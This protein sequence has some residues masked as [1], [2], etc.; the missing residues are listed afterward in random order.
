MREV[1]GAVARSTL[2]AVPF[3][4]EQKWSLCVCEL[5]SR[6]GTHPFDAAVPGT[7]KRARL[8]ENIAAADVELTPEDLREIDA[9][10]SKIT[11]QGARYPRELEQMVGR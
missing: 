2:R 6:L 1:P 3:T 4:R 9:G 7:T 5:A 10:A 11:A 8:E